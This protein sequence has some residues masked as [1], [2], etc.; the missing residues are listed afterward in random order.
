MVLNELQRQRQEFQQQLAELRAVVGQ[1][2]GAAA[3]IQS[4]TVAVT[5]VGPR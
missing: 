5:G 1:G 3:V 2:R 4:A